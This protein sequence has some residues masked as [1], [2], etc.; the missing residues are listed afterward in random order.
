MS[1]NKC[2]IDFDG[3]INDYSE[4]M[5]Q[6]FSQNVPAGYS[7]VLT[8]N[9]FWQLKRMGIHEAKWLNEK[10]E[11]NINIEEWNRK[12]IELIE[13]E[14]YL[15]FDKLFPFS[16][17]ALMKLK[18]KYKLILV[19]KRSSELNLLSQLSVYEIENFFDDVIIIHHDKKKETAVREKY[20]FSANDVF[21]GDTEDD[22]E[23]GMSLGLKT[24]FVLSGIRNLW[25]TKKYKNF[26]IFENILKIAE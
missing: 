6:F 4:R 10:F 17:Q 3:T 1:Q 15:S 23:A 9:E 20:D 8:K 11:T 19:T 12:K 16:I 18:A 25:I 22:I 7:N 21:I 2:F 14:K 24:Y 13:T 26:N 5:F